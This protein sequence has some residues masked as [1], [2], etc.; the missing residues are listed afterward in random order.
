MYKSNLSFAEGHFDECLNLIKD[1]RLYKDALHIFDEGSLEWKA[2]WTA[3][4]DYLIEKKYYEEAGLI[5]TRSEQYQKAVTAFQESQ[6]WELALCAATK[7]GNSE[8]QVV[9]LALSFAETLKGNKHY[10]EAAVLLDQYV[11]DSEGAIATLIEGHNW[12]EA[13][14][15]IHKY[16]RLDLMETHLRPNILNQSSVIQEMIQEMTE[17]ITTYTQRLKYVRNTKKMK[18]TEVLWDETF[19]ADADLYSDTSS[20]SG[21]SRKLPS[22]ASRQTSSLS[23]SLMTQCTS[24]KKKKQNQKKYTLKEGSQ[25]EDLALIAALSDLFH[26]SGRMTGEVGSLLKTLVMMGYDQEAVTLQHNFTDLLKLIENSTSDVWPT[27]KLDTEMV[28]GPQSTANTLIMALQQKNQ[29]MSP[30]ISDPD[31]R[32]PP[33]IVKSETWKLVLLQ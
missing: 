25:N 23:G 3:Y 16:K 30:I 22:S 17:K 26:S 27:C 14:R 18:K 7:A 33:P 1:Q 8:N 2:I 12:K 15:M 9:E 20:V 32:N 13:I 11:M 29:D 31:L 5:Y 6:N 4:G 10:F 19:S 24:R 21:L 28:F